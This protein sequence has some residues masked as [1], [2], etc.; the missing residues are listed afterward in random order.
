MKE[1]MI[2]GPIGSQVTAREIVE[3]FRQARGEEVL[4][5]INSEGGSVLE[6][7]AILTAIRQHDEKV[8]G[9]IDGYAFSM[10]GI[11]ALALREEEGQGGLTM[12]ENGF[13]ML[14]EVRVGAGGT[15]E[16]LE[17]MLAQIKAMNAAMAAKVANAFSITEAEAAK[18]LKDEIWMNGAEA[19][20]AGIVSSLNPAEAMAAQFD[21]S[22]F[23]NMPKEFLREVQ[24]GTPAKDKADQ[25]TNQNN[26]PTM[27]LFKLFQN[28]NEV[29]PSLEVAEIG[30]DDLGAELAEAQK[31]LDEAVATHNAQLIARDEKH[32]Q[33]LQN[34]LSEQE[35]EL[36]AKHAEELAKKDEA[37]AVANN[38]A[39]EK[40]NEILAQAGHS[41]VE[42][43]EP[44]ERSI[45]EQYL[46]LNPGE[47]RAKFRKEHAEELKDAFGSGALK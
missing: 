14:H 44:E 26:K 39:E 42:T 15:V 36:S 6:G 8:Y 5:R 17:R 37:I 35:A 34:A 11:I 9:Q 29:E 47:D 12:P 43:T 27:K 41:P 38:S 4:V 30:P 23:S 2:D 32:A 3:E 20:E 28:H 24:V 18:R 19:L 46:A 10:A 21:V 7:E 33:A 22:N 40:A 13:L 16:D 25:P 1:I 31:S 45:K